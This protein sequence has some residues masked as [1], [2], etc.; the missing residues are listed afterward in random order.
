ME[1]CQAIKDSNKLLVDAMSDMSK[2]F[3]LMA[4]TMKITMQ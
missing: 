4:K 3:I 1:L 2:S